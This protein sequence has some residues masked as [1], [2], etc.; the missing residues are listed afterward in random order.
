MTC[1]TVDIGM[2]GPHAG[3][4]TLLAAF[5]ANPGSQTSDL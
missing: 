4:M 1:H 3:P 2:H 5:P